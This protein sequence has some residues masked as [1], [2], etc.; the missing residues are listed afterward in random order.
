MKII[1]HFRTF[2]F[3]KG[4]KEE[5]K[6]FNFWKILEFLSRKPIICQLWIIKNNFSFQPLKDMLI[7]ML[8][9]H[10]RESFKHSDVLM[11]SFIPQYI[12]WAHFYN[13]DLGLCLNWSIRF[14]KKKKKGIE[15]WRD[16]PVDYN[17]LRTGISS[18]LI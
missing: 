18:Y 1:F 10:H 15:R 4:T 3:F 2:I 7:L 11:T 14:F 6:F 5:G 12:L 9:P 17:E 8:L 16:A 13:W